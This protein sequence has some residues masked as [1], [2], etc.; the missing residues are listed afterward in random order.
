MPKAR[1]EKPRQRPVNV[2]VRLT[3]VEKAL[4]KSSAIAAE[5]N[6]SIMVRQAVKLWMRENNGAEQPV[7]AAMD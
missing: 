4:W 7:R 2:I 3:P 1:K 6:M 5:V